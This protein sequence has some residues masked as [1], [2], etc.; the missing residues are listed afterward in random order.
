MS[1]RLS[2]V[3]MLF[4]NLLGADDGNRLTQLLGADVESKLSC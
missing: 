4:T 1:R 3:L 2:Q